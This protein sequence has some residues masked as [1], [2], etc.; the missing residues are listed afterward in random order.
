MDRRAARDA[1]VHRPTLPDALGTGLAGPY[2]RGVPIYEFDVRTADD[3]LWNVE[4]DARTGLV[5]ELEREVA[6]DDPAFADYRKIEESDA[7]A[8]VLAIHPGSSVEA[9]EYV[10]EQDGTAAYEFDLLTP[11]GDEMKIEVDAATGEVTESNFEL[12]EIG[13]E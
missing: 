12:W 8:T 11:Y 7:R 2:T 13:V 5:S 3:I 10:V 9:T 4:C 6:P 1:G